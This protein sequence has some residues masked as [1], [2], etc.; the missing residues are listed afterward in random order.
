MS[1]ADLLDDDR[2]AEAELPAP[3]LRRI[4][5]AALG[6]LAIG[7][8]GML[9]WAAITP[10]E[11]AVIAEG[12]LIS[13]GRR[14]SI[15]LLEPGI[16][17]DLLV[18]EGQRVAAGQPL[19]RLDVTQAEA[20]ANQA[21]ALRA[22][23]AARVARLR[24][25]QR[26]EREMTI[27]PG[28]LQAAAADPVF[29]ALIEDEGRLFQARLAAFDG[30]RAVQRRKIAQMQEQMAAAQAQRTAAGT[31][32]RANR[33]EL[34][35]V[36]RL[37]ADGF[38]TRTRQLELQREE[39]ELLG[40]AGQFAA[41]EAQSREAIAQAEL[42]EATLLLNRRSEVGRDL[43]DAQAQLADAT[44]RL[45][46]A[47]DVLRR[48]EVVA[49]EGGVVTDIR[50]VTAG[51][52][53]AA[54]VPILDLVPADD[55]LVVEAQVNPIDVE[56]LQVGQPARVR[57]TAFRQR[58]TPLVEA[59]LIYVSADRQTDPRGASF[60][61][62]RAELDPASL[63]QATGV[64][65]AAGM[66]AELFVLGEKRSALDYLLRPITASLRRAMR[67]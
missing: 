55:R 65:L 16:L 52:S 50:F 41:Q 56:E 31:R 58:E 39:A 57:L 34:A 42:E 51:S 2:L 43:Q 13:E 1:T 67:D 53:I 62:A 24:A 3:S 15:Q 18:R 11:R 30:A 17:R 66:P 49:P 10:L 9:G 26:E 64:P 33:E 27:P 19:I 12:S 35:G 38:A 48:R 5:L 44:E 63:H 8:G 22:T 47:E 21:R 28:L 7:L 59:K 46:G 60:F 32:L 4:G 29:A 14:K 37:R 23:A 36:N 61:L 6:V 40:L 25:E 45:R 54:G 20:A